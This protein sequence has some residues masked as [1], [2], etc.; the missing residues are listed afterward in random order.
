MDYDI[1][2]I[3]GGPAGATAAL[4]SAQLGLKAAAFE[5]GRHPRFHIGESL[6]PRM[7]TLVRKLGLEDGLK[8]LPHPVSSGHDFAG[9]EV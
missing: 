3:G 5:K 8:A 9:T 2:I 6:L 7:M 1:L 4:R